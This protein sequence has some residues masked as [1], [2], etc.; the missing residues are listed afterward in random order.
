[1]ASGSSAVAHLRQLRKLLAYQK[2]QWG[3]KC[4][5]RRFMSNI[6]GVGSDGYD[7]DAI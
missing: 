6:Y 5:L 7:N 3:R 4:L 1:M 2:R